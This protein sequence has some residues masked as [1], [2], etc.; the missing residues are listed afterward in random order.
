[1]CV[2]L[3]LESYLVRVYMTVPSFLIH[4]ELNLSHGGNGILG[5]VGVE[6]ESTQRRLLDWEPGALGVG[7]PQGGSEDG[8]GADSTKERVLCSAE[9]GVSTNKTAGPEL[10]KAAP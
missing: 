4:S 1:M 9:E 8:A 6:K 7:A 2:K 5:E 10:E 3:R